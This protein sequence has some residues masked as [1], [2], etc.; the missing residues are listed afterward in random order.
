ML[1]KCFNKLSKQKLKCF[2]TKENNDKT[3]LELE[4]NFKN[5]LKL[6][7]EDPN[8]EGLLKTPKRAAE[9]LLFFTKGYKQSTDELINNAI[10][11]ENHDEMVIVKNIEIYSMCEHHL[12]PFYGKCHIGYI[13]D[14]KVI[15][16]SKLARIAE[17][18]AR[19]LQVQ[20]RLTRQITEAIDENLN[21]KGVA[22][23][24]EAQHMCMISRGVQ[25][26]GT[27]TM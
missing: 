9:A 18:F 21:P 15:G 12:V 5:I 10:F 20:E 6:I 23:V 22:C 16:L 1:R 19:R 13:P 27:S 2:S 26:P 11:Q 25:K 8:R 14:G 7:G 3:L 4:N 17:L 24:I